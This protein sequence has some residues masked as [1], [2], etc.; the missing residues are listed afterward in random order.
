MASKYRR[1][2]ENG[3]NGNVKYLWRRKA[4]QRSA[5]SLA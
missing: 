4:Q 3:G 5:I 1:A 2:G